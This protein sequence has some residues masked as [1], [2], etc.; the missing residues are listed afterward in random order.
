ML[1]RLP[2]PAWPAR[3]RNLLRPGWLGDVLSGAALALLLFLPAA[4]GILAP[5]PLA[6][7]HR[8]LARSPNS[9][10]AF[11]HA[12]TFAL[13]FFALHLA[14]LP[15]SMAG[16]LGPLGGALTV[17]V[18]PAAALTWAAPLAL[19]RWVFGA[20]TLLA[21]PFMWVILEALRAKGPLAFP[22]GAPGYALTDTPLAPLASLGGVSLLTLL[23]TVTASAL[24]ALGSRRHPGVVLAL[25][26]VWSV[27]LL[28]GWRGAPA[29]PPP[30]RTAVLVQGAIDPRVKAQ[31][32]TLEELNVYLGLTRRALGRGPADLVVWP[33]TASP[34]PASDPR[35]LGPLRN[36][37]V[38]VLLGAPGDV[39][40]QARN[41]AYGVDGRVTGRQDKRVLVPFGE[42][43]PFA[44][45]LGF[46]YTPLLSR[47]GMPGYISATPGRA[48]NVLPLR[49]LRAGVSICYESV[50]PALSRQTVRAGANLLVVMSNDAWFGR[51]P[52]AEQH[53]RL[54][55]LRAI[56]TGRYLLR[57]GNDGV[58]AVVDPWG[59]VVFRAPR[60]E[61]AAYR[62]PFGVASTL[63]PFVRYGDWTLAGSVVFLLALLHGR[64]RGMKKLE[65]PGPWLIGGE[66]HALGRADHA[67]DRY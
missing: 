16:I 49:D 36:L 23:V 60:G 67:E 17:L 53:F 32:R 1:Y 28:W 61:R 65:V 47:L 4:A 64:F 12:F 34:L 57:A 18:L 55:R 42:S 66:D 44:K 54:G 13:A 29:V 46:L 40:G 19:T 63:T 24:A 11:R 38:P 9:R 7:L 21:L 14:W 25:L 31:G 43:L 62:A 50:F 22:W 6:A 10:M 51:G 8:R 59:R 2:F 37:G 30:T 35:V 39:P 48:L 52:G 20:R 3:F 33:E 5:L 56:E 15:L 41:S 26:A 45:A 27:A 58:S